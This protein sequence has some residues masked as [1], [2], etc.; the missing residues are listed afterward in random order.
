MSGCTKASRKIET[1]SPRAAAVPIGNL[2]ARFTEL[3][4]ALTVAFG[5]VLTIAWTGGLSWFLVSLL[6]LVV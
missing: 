5:V 3:W 6:L 2:Q 4:P 1:T